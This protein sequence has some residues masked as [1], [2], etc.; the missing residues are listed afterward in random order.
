M[1][2]IHAWLTFRSLLF[3]SFRGTFVSKWFVYYIAKVC[4][5]DDVNKK[6]ERRFDYVTW[7]KH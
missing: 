6:T 1:V 5:N 4:Y 3:S 7:T 2:K